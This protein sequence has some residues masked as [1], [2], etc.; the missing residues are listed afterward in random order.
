MK[1]PHMT[2]YK[3]LGRLCGSI[4][5]LLL[6]IIAKVTVTMLQCIVWVLWSATCYRLGCMKHRLRQLVAVGCY[7]CNL[8]RGTVCWIMEQTNDTIPHYTINLTKMFKHGLVYFSWKQHGKLGSLYHRNIHRC[9]N[10]TLHRLSILLATSS[11]T[12][13]QQ[14]FTAR[15]YPAW[16]SS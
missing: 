16:F 14:T 15:L 2:E 8:P 13:F 11:A 10:H 5:V 9:L 7:C 6:H 3:V 1:A 4:T 12:L